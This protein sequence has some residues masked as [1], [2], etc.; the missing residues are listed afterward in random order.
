MAKRGRTP[1]YTPHHCTI[2]YKFCSLGAT[3]EDLAEVFGVS[4]NTIGNW[5]ARY[6]FAQ[7]TTEFTVTVD[8]HADLVA[9]NP[10]DFFVEPYAATY[11]FALPPDLAHELGGYLDL[12]PLGA[13][14]RV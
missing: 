11:P 13:Q 7:R 3:N 6:T 8:L 9:V 14:M 10:F 5:V 2:A 12:E 1:S 4:R